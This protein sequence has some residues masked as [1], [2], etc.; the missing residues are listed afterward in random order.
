MKGYTNVLDLIVIDEN[1][2]LLVPE[3]V[4]W[5]DKFEF[6]GNYE[7]TALDIPDGIVGIGME[8]FLFCRNLTSVTIPDSVSNIEESAFSCCDSLS[9]II[10]SGNNANYKSINNCCLSKTGD[11]LIFG[12]KNSKIPDSVTKIKAYAFF[13]CTGLTSITIPD[14][15]TNIEE[16]AFGGCDSLSSI[17]V[18]EGNPNYK[19]IDN[20][21]LSKDGDV[22]IFG[23]KNSKIPDSVT[24]IKAGAFHGCTGLTAITIPDSVT[25]IGDGAFMNCSSIKSINIPNRVTRIGDDAFRGCTGLTAITIPDSVTEIG[26]APFRVCPGII[27]IEIPAC[28]VKHITKLLDSPDDIASVTVRITEKLPDNAKDV[29]RIVDH[30]DPSN[31]T[32]KVPVDCEEAYRH[33]PDFEGKFK[34]IQAVLD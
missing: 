23:C 5:I 21:C 11:E 26:I 6:M 2:K 34:E 33:H 16:Y 29:L 12:C 28:L 14:N 13:G 31:V 19:S 20:C 17:I 32:L 30:L 15:V 18:S 3:G 22:L 7:I 4:T 1:G 9:S 10:V 8:A 25:E 27:S 24:K